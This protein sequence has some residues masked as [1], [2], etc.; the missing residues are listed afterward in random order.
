[1]RS[2][3]PALV[4]LG[5]NYGAHGFALFQTV[6]LPS[7]L[8]QIATGVRV[9]LSVSLIVVVSCEM[10]GADQGLG[11][12]IWTAGQSFSTER[13]YVGLL[14]CGLLGGGMVVVLKALER[15]L[16]PWAAQ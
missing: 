6:Y 3:N 15:K 16:A 2:V 4:E 9:S 7:C 5:R 1:V 10:L 13:L 11:N 14:T 8:P 12:L